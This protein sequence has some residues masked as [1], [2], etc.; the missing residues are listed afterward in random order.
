MSA[1]SAS[2]LRGRLSRT[3]CDQR[4]KSEAL[5]DGSVQASILAFYLAQV[6]VET[7]TASWV[8]VRVQAPSSAGFGLAEGKAEVE[9]REEGE[10]EGRKEGRKEL[11]PCE[12]QVTLTWQVGKYIQ[13]VYPRGMILLTQWGLYKTDWIGLTKIGMLN[14]HKLTIDRQT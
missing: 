3:S 12:N 5:G 7:P 8:G 4:S 13:D 11:N 1:A 14:Q 6:R 9:Q 10:G 2:T